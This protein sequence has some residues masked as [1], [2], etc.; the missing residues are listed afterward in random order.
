M[1]LWGGRFDGKPAQVMQA[2]NSSFELDKRMHAEDIKVNGGRGSK[3][4]ESMA[5]PPR[6]AKYM[7]KL[8]EE[9]ES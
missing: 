9:L 4:S 1:S 2:F 3:G 5:T 6:E 7:P 8:W